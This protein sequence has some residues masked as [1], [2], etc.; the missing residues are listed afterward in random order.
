VA[1]YQAAAASGKLKTASVITTATAF[2]S[3][4]HD[5]AGAF[6]T[7]ASSKATHKANPKLGDTATGQIQASAN[8]KAVLQV[9]YSVEVAAA[10][11]YLYALG[12]LQDNATL[13]LAASILPVESQ[14]AVILGILLNKDAKTSADFLPSFITQDPALTPD[15]Y[16]VATA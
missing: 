11:T 5:H 7:A 13:A 2:A 6:A 14:H 10:S 12:A 4:H 8:E 3:H 1:A 9:I 15:K 16:P